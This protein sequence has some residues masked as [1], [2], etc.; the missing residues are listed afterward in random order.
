M[1][2]FLDSG[3]YIG[4][5]HPKDENYE[6]CKELLQILKTGVHGQLF[7]SN[8]I[9]A[10]S[11]TLVAVRTRNNA[12]AIQNIYELFLGVGQLARV[13]RLNED[14]E[15]DAWDLFRKIN[16]P[17]SSEVVSYVDCTNIILC[18]SYSIEA[19]LSY[20]S[21]FDGWINRIF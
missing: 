4:L 21:H 11:V 13:L 16:S 14:N 20:D 7:T 8:F 5:T 12:H 9:M 17:K 10:E 2:I 1:A 3:F 18:R 15:S 6:R 19:I